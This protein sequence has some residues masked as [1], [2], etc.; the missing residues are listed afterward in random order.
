MSDE[1]SSYQPDATMLAYEVANKTKYTDRSPEQ[2]LLIDGSAG[3]LVRN[4]VVSLRTFLPA[5]PVEEEGYLL[6]E[7]VLGSR[8][9]NLIQE[10]DPNGKEAYYDS[11]HLL[12]VLGSADKL[13]DNGYIKSKSHFISSS[14]DFVYYYA[15]NEAY[16]RVLLTIEDYAVAHPN[17]V[18]SLLSGIVEF[19]SLNYDYQVA[20]FDRVEALVTTMLTIGGADALAYIADLEDGLYAKAPANMQKFL[21]DDASQISLYDSASRRFHAESL[22]SHILAAARSVDFNDEDAPSVAKFFINDVSNRSLYC[23][24]DYKSLVEKLG[25]DYSVPLLLNNL[26]SENV[27][28]R[29]LAAEAL[30]SLELGRVGVT[31]DGVNYLGKLY[32]LGRYNDPDFFVRRLNSSGLLGVL[33]PVDGIQGVFDLNLESTESILQAAVKKLVSEDLF[34]PKADESRA[35]RQQREEYTR[36]FIENYENIS[37]S[38]LENTD[39]RLNSLQLHEQGWFLMYYIGL[40]NA[41]DTEGISRLEKFVKKYGDLGLKS[42]LALEYGGS[43]ETLL[44]FAESPNLSDEAKNAIFRNYYGMVNEAFNWRTVFTNLEDSVGVEFAAQAHEAFIRKSSEFLHAAGI[45]AK[46]E[47]GD[48]AMPELLA[49]MHILTFSMRALHELYT[50]DSRLKLE[51]SPQYKTEYDK[52]GTR[53]EAALSS[54]SLVDK[55]SELRV[56]V[57]VRSTPTVTTGRNVGGEARINFAVTNLANGDIARIGFDLSDPSV[58]SEDSNKLPV[59]SLDLGVGRPDRQADIWPSQR[60]GRVLNLVKDTEGGHNQRS[61]S[62]DIADEFPNIAKAFKRHMD[63]KF[64]NKG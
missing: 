15:L 23:I 1:S 52:E 29:G 19:A 22:H 58:Y 9:L 44:A 61:F 49:H 36:L 11:E 53:I 14:N 2:H 62:P 50:V 38:I 18:D 43:G 60:V 10:L 6:G 12:G 28:T 33:S 46:G 57:S 21:Q 51:S 37:E 32:D 31:E 40:Q 8:V 16:L 64:V 27:L 20:D 54:Y 48:V 34:M 13:F 39:L 17:E 26:R 45:I 42:F 41:D 4:A 5:E 59:V 24:D 55:D 56:T 25:P 7:R 47:G 3:N 63:S 30:F 35:D